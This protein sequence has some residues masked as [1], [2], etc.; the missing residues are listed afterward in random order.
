MKKIRELIKR[1][2]DWWFAPWLYETDLC[3]GHILIIALSLVWGFIFLGLF[4]RFFNTTGTVP[5]FLAL[6]SFLVVMECIYWADDEKKEINN[7]WGSIAFILHK[8]IEALD[9][10]LKVFCGYVWIILSPTNLFL[11]YHINRDAMMAFLIV[12]GI[13]GVFFSIGIVYLWI[14]SLKYKKKVK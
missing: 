6:L 2:N 1:Y 9:A 10:T 7:F 11:G 14:N 8:K 13:L 4:V 3:M 12:L 5:L